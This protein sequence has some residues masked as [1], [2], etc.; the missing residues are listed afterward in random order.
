M[1]LIVCTHTLAPGAKS[2]YS[3]SHI[4]PM[5]VLI[6]KYPGLKLGPERGLNFLSVHQVH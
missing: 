5:A 3:T 2:T 4:V 6:A 1:K